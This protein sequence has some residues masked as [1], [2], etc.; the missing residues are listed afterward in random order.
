MA[1]HGDATHSEQ[2]PASEAGDQHLG[3]VYAKALLGASESAGQTEA[4]LEQLNSLVDDLLPVVPRMKEVLYSG[5]VAPEDKVELLDRVLKGR[6]TPLMLNF[7]KVLA[8]HDRLSA[9]PAIRRSAL[10]QFDQLRGRVQ[11]H[12]TTAA[13]L[14]DKQRSDIL[15]R[16]R[17]L[18]GGQPYLVSQVDPDLIS[19]IVL[20]VGD[21]VY[22]GSVSTRL[23][24]LREDMIDRSVH[25][26]QRRRDRFSSPEGN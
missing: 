5:L 2:A 20:R 7:L 22:D 21:T 15:Q 17:Q 11:W 26:I 12:V 4:V 6:A 1:A 23:A 13:P 18:R 25:E 24:R 9:L 8:G 16:L 19:G 10:R 3:D 14:T